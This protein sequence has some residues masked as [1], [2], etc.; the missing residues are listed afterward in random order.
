MPSFARTIALAVAAALAAPCSAA[1]AK[2]VLHAAE[3]ATAESTTCG[4]QEAVN[5]LPPEGGVVTVPPGRYVMRQSVVLRPHV[6]V[7][8][9]GSSTILT[10]PAEVYSKLARPARKGDTAV[11]VQSS[12]GFRPGDQVAVFDDVM[13]GWYMGHAIL[14]KVEPGRLA[15]AAPIENGHPDGVY[16]LERSAAV[17]N[18]FP[19]FRASTMHFGPPV[20]D[21]AVLDLTLDG[22]LAENPGPWTDFTLSAIHFANVSDGLIRGV[23]VRGSVGDGIGVQGGR[24]NRV[25]SCLV[26]ECRGHGFHPGTSLSGATFSGNIGRNNGGDGL[27]FCCQVVGITV[28]GNLFHGNKRSGIG[29]LGA[30]CGT[31]DSF[32]VV[33]NNVCRENALWGIEAGGGRNNVISGNVCV[34]N[35]QSSPGRY[36]G[37]IIS[38][39]THTLV[40]GNRCGSE[41]EKPAQKF[42]IEESG[43]SD[44]NLFTGNLCTGNRDGGLATVGKNTQVSA[45]LGTNH[46][47]GQPATPPGK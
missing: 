17:V 6:T 26:E 2:R 24:D 42:G 13:H 9:S 25:E 38:D 12:Q 5:A 45:N 34:D 11:E 14:A 21:V 44:H 43:A 32:N 33:A 39:S 29:G 41:A 37:I 40:T 46:K 30:G 23:T 3:F 16:S 7:Q 10:R 47:P 4:I 19:F 8:G 27:Y 36:S 18:Y 28:T 22:N 35:S 15:L 20:A 31:S 1:E